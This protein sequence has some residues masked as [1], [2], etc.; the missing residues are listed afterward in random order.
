MKIQYSV[1]DSRFT[2]VPNE[3]LSCEFLSGA[4][5]VTWMQLAS[6]CRDG[7]SDGRMYRSLADVSREL[8]VDNCNF[9][10]AVKRLIQAGGAERD[11]GEIRL[12]IPDAPA[13][14]PTIE[15][16]IQEQPKRKHSMT[17]KEAWVLIKEGWNKAKPEEWLRLD[18]GLNLPV[19]IAL[20]THAKRLNIE[21]PDYGRFVA[22]VCR[23]A[24]T[25]P[26]WGK[27]NM[28]ASSVFGFSK[29]TDK[30]FE[31]VEKLYKAGAK[32]EV[33]LDC[34]CDADIIARYHDKGRTELTK[35]I[36]LEAE[37]ESAAIEHVTS[38]PEADYDESAVYLYFAP[39]VD[40]PVYW[41]GKSRTSTMYLFS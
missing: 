27:Q 39:G 2:A 7:V 10:V 28:K 4:N 21:R 33:K 9:R 14:P 24:T 41:T 18:G 6:V 19:M 32:V 20:E 15:E 35:V 23:G 40:R 13:A 26:W 16:E 1:P 37:D 38:L 8:R 5:K 17:Q 22:Q 11:G 12:V 25:D 3:L 31:N 36:R 34:S 30:K 29:V